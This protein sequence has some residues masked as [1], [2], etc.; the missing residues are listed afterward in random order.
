M[1]RA[2]LALLVLLVPL[3]IAISTAGQTSPATTRVTMVLV[4]GPELGWSEPQFAEKLQRLI[5][6]RANFELVSPLEARELSEK[7][8]GRFSREYLVDWGMHT[9]CRYIV[10]CDI[11]KEELKV[12]R[13]FSLPFVLNQKRVAACLELEYRL[14][15]CFRGRLLSAEKV[16]RK[17]YGPSAMQFLNNSDVDPDLYFSYLD[18]KNL[19][20]DLETSAAEEVFAELE[21]VA[22]QR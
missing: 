1:K 5:G 21:R 19:F 6:R 15:D 4:N 9:D 13:G 3:T 17:C 22:Q 10:W 14:V 7:L 2:A 20:D 18:Q 16:E 8:E 11:V 12:E